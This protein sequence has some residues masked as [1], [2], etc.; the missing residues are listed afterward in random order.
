[1]NTRDL[2]LVGAGV[3]VG[4]LLVGVMNKKKVDS[5]VDKISLPDT[6]SQ[7]VPPTSTT[8]I[9]G[10]KET[11]IASTSTGQETLVDPKLATCNENWSKYSRNKKFRSTEEKQSTYD[12]FIETCLVRTL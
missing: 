9:K 3:V 1:M 6:S 4:Y 2:I 11:A 8:D 10:T 7:T 12:K 5:K